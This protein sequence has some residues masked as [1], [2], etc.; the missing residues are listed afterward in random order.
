MSE[1]YVD[2]R[3]NFTAIAGD[4]ISF[5]VGM[6]F[7]N[8]TSVVPSLVNQLTDF[9]PLIGLV[10]TIANGAWLLPQLIAAH[11]VTN[12]ERKKP[13]VM[14]T[15]LAGRP[16]YLLVALAIFLTGDTYPWLILALFFLAETVF[17]I[18]DGLSMVAWFDIISKSIPPTKR[19][20]LYSTGQ[21]GGGLLA[22]AAGL[23][24]RL[25]LGPRG[26]AF[27]YNYGLLFLL[28]AAFL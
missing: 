3:R 1:E 9:A 22:I 6:A 21:I 18:A 8:Y 14:A 12:R 24:V 20:R 17:T 15:G 7:V 23:V 10:T 11:Y 25:I 26:P 28:S 16:M 2:Y 27:P 13:Y 19:G 5:L 4:W